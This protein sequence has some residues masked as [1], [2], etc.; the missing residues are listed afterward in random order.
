[1]V[2]AVL[3]AHALDSDPLTQREPPIRVF[4]FVSILNTGIL[5]AEAVNKSPMPSLFTIKDA[6]D[7]VPEMEATGSVP[8][9]PL[10]S[11]FARGEDVPIPTLPVEVPASKYI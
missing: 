3:P 4:P 6:K 7:V 10:T 2:P 9:A 5:L 1:M 8:E 11:N